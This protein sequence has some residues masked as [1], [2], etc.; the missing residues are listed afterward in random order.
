MPWIVGN[1]HRIMFLSGVLTLTMVYAAIAPEAALRS[2][3]GE[4][5][6]GPV[7]DVV[8][9]NWGAL[10]AL[11][12]VMLLYGARRPAV[13]PLA[14]SVAG[15]SKAIFIVLVLSH[16]GRFLGYQ[17]GIAVIV[18]LVWVVVF[19]AYLLA[20]GRTPKAKL[21]VGAIGTA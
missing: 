12:G 15:A 8:V 2:T 1:I 14:L 13:R 17:A 4:S 10:I 5:V 3:F 6:S 21:K 18:D 7:A 11:M 16:G 9:R 19:G 20:A